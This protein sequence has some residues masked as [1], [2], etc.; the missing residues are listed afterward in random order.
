MTRKSLL[1]PR[2]FAESVEESVIFDAKPQLQGARDGI[3]RINRNFPPVSLY[4]SQQGILWVVFA[5][6]V[7]EAYELSKSATA[8]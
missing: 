3:L 6:E 4:H 7:V 5:Y 8:S 1:S 2:R